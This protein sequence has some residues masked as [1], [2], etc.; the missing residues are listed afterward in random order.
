MLHKI[1]SYS[2]P[3]QKPSERM[4]DSYADSDNKS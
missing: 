1:L 4:T 3:L 2:I